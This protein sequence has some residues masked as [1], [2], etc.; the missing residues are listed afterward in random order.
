MQVT[1]NYRSEEFPTR[2]FPDSL[3]IGWIA[4]EVQKHLPELVTTDSEGYKGIAY[5]H[6]TV[7]VAAAVNELQDKHDAELAALRDEVRELRE[8]VN[9]LLQ[10]K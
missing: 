8:L 10:N 3:Q 2:K 6:A 5:A 1:Y 7:L 9:K 4:D